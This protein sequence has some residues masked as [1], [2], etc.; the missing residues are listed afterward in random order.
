[1]LFIVALAAGMW[2]LVGI[3]AYIVLYSMWSKRKFVGNT[4]GEYFRGDS[5]LIG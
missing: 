5:L 4:K 2:G 1:M 3:I